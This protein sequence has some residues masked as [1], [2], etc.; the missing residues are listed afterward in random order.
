ML[1][2]PTASAE[3]AA[4]AEAEEAF[5]RL[6]TLTRR[7]R[8]L[9]LDRDAIVIGRE[10]GEVP[11]MVLSVREQ[12]QLDTIGEAVSSSDA[13]LASM[14]GTFGRLTAGEPMPDR[15]QLIRLAGRARRAWPAVCAATARFIAWLDRMDTPRPSPAEPDREHHAV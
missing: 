1:A 12:R 8:T 3:P 13:R 2:R 5:Y 14:L 11:A 4:G 7:R 6:T 9:E 10:L 15:E